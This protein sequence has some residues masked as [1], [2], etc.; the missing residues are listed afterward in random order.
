MAITDVPDSPLSTVEVLVA[1]GAAQFPLTLLLLKHL[2]GDGGEFRSAGE[3]AVGIELDFVHVR[4]I[5]WIGGKVNRLGT[6]PRLSHA[7]EHFGNRL[8]ILFIGGEAV[9]I[10]SGNLTDGSVDR[11]TTLGDDLL[12]VGVL[13]FV[14]E[15][16]IGTGSAALGSTLCQSLHWFQKA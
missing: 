1:K 10:T 7:V 6:V 16:I 4:K 12:T 15:P 8:L 2:Q 3:D 14:H 13:C 5:G 11:I 9:P